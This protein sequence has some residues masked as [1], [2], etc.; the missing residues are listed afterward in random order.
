MGQP[1][2]LGQFQVVD[3]CPGCRQFRAA[4]VAEGRHG[5]LESEALGTVPV[6]F[7]ADLDITGGNS[8]SPVLD[9]HGELV[10]LA[11]DGIWEA[12]AS[13]WVYDE[14]MTRAISVDGRYIRWVMQEAYPAPRVL[15]E[16]GL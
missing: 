12:V 10:G 1:P 9:A 13:N 14:E 6:N 8:G 2:L 15:E 3:Q 7:L 11:F 5:G 16:L 4:E